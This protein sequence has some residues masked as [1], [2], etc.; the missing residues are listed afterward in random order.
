MKNRGDVFAFLDLLDIRV[1]ERVCSL[2][3]NAAPHG[4]AACQ[5]DYDNSA[6]LGVAQRLVGKKSYLSGVVLLKALFQ[7][8][9]ISVLNTGKLTE[10]L[11]IRVV[12]FAFLP[13]LEYKL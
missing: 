13:V 7:T 1:T 11:I 6:V 3:D 8:G 12:A 5:S 10:L 2:R 9:G 4:C